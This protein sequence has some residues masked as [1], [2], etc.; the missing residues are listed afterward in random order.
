[1]STSFLKRAAGR[2]GPGAVMA[3]RLENTQS[4]RQV[5]RW[6][7]YRQK[8]LLLKYVLR[9]QFASS[10][11]RLA[12]SDQAAPPSSSAEQKQKPYVVNGVAPSAQA[13]EPIDPMVFDASKRPPPPDYHQLVAE[14]KMTREEVG[15]KARRL[16]KQVPSFDLEYPELKKKRTV[17]V[18]GKEQD[19]MQLELETQELMRVQ[20]FDLPSVF[21]LPTGGVHATC[22]SI[23]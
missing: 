10:H 8:C 1:M 14:G 6:E 9:H 16:F 13:D 5:V 20:V 4:R 2:S 19:I 3:M 11:L 18:D 12:A 21:R 22:F 17:V 23:G 7:L 15:K